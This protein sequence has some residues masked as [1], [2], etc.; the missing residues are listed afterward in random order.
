AGDR[1]RPSRPQRRTPLPARAPVALLLIYRVRW[2]PRY[3]KRLESDGAAAESVPAASATPAGC[4]ER[5]GRDDSE[6]QHRRGAD[7]H[8]LATD[9]AN[10][11]VG[12]ML[13]AGLQAIVID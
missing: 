1:G 4:G 7:V 2:L 12:E 8:L 10:V 11:A 3:V 13:A 6:H 5:S 9:A